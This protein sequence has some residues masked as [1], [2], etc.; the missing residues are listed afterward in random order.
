MKQHGRTAARGR[1]SDCDRLLVRREY[2]FQSHFGY[3]LRDVLGTFVDSCPHK[4]RTKLGRRGEEKEK[5]KR[6]IET[7]RDLFRG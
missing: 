6:E 5:E 1:D 7:D 3:E 4:Q 2:T